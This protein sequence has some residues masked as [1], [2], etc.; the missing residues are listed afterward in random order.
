MRAWFHHYSVCCQLK[1][2][3][4]SRF[5]GNFSNERAGQGRSFIH[6]LRNSELHG[7]SG[8]YIP[9]T[10]Y[11]FAFH[12]LL[13]SKENTVT[14]VQRKLIFVVYHGQSWQLGWVVSFISIN[15]RVGSTAIYDAI[16]FGEFAIES[17]RPRMKTAGRAGHVNSKIHQILVLILITES[18]SVYTDILCSFGISKWPQNFDLL[19]N[20]NWKS[21]I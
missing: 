1:L 13:A 18:K 11:T 20:S 12:F 6:M 17:I 21:R 4:I 8:I 3:N 7:V 5:K 14:S 15:V 9:S 10:Y 19:V 2:V 16:S